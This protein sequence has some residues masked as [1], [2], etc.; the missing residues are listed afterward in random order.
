MAVALRDGMAEVTELWSRRGHDLDFGVGISLGFATL[1][2]IGFEGRSD[3]GAIGSVV[4]LASR[5]CDEARG[6]QILISGK[7][8]ESIQGGVE[9]APLPPLALKG[10]GRPVAAFRV[11]GLN[12]GAPAGPALPAGLTVREVEV[13]R[14][15]AG[16]GSSSEIAE[17]LVISVRTVERH[18]SNIYLKIEAHGRAEATA[19]AITHG[20]FYPH[21]P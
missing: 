3:Y 1:G 9:S 14:L 6:G 18:I 8:L 12:E 13:L 4:N 21:R 17:E 16:G 2:E 15:V 20:L 19:W 5:L 7:A 10:F 11:I